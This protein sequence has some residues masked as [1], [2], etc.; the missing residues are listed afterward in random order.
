MRKTK[1]LFKG[2]VPRGNSGQSSQSSMNSGEI[3][4]LKSWN[5]S[6]R[7]TN[8]FHVTNPF[9]S[10][11]EEIAAEGMIASML[12]C[13]VMSDNES[14]ADQNSQM[15]YFSQLNSSRASSDSANFVSGTAMNCGNV[16]PP[17]NNSAID[18]GDWPNSNGEQDTS[19]D[20]SKWVENM[21]AGLAFG[22]ITPQAS[23]DVDPLGSGV[24][25]FAASRNAVADTA[26]TSSGNQLGKRET[27]KE[28][29]LQ[30]YTFT[31]PPVL[32]PSTFQLEGT[33]ISQYAGSDGRASPSSGITGGIK[34]TEATREDSGWSMA[35]L[36][37]VQA[38]LVQENGDHAQRAEVL[39]KE[40]DELRRGV[41]EMKMEGRINQDKMETSMASVKGL[42]EKRISEMTAIMAQRDQQADERLKLISETMHRRDI[43]VD[44]RMVNLITTVQDLTLG[45]KAVAATVPSRP[46]PVPV[47]LNAANVP[48]TSAF[49]TQPPTN[50]EVVQRQSGTK[51]DKRNLNPETVEEAAKGNTL[52]TIHEQALAEAII[53]AMSKGLE[54]L[55]A[56][57]EA[58]NKP[59][60]YRG[61]RDGIIDGWLV[62][63]KRYLEKAHS[64]DTTLE[65]AWTIVEFLE[66][67][68]QDYITN[69]SEAERD[70]DEKIFAL[71]ARRFGTGST[72][73]QIQQLFRTRNQS[74]DEDYMQYLDA[75]ENLRSQGIPNEEITVRR[76]EIMQ[77][78]VEGVRSFELK[79]NLA[80]MYAQEQYVDTPPTVEALRFTVQQYLHMRGSIR[81]ENYPAPQQKPL[82]ASQQNPIPAAAP[83]VPNVQPPPQPVAVRQ[84]PPRACFNCGDPS[85]FVADCPLKDRARKP[86]QQ[87]VNSCRTN[88]AGE[89]TFPSNPHGMNN[90]VVPAALAAQGP[91]TIRVNCDCTGHTASECMVPENAATEEQVKA[92]WYAPVTKSA[93]FA[94]TDD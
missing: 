79:R 60:K 76:Y 63:M 8:S 85:H 58:K 31:T 3:E 64:K 21:N 46:L 43:D 67:E 65:R 35:Q 48:S 37:Q 87:L 23:L 4:H 75:L 5:E 7:Q 11:V 89:W 2:W 94:D 86:V 26:S 13:D 41:I 9:A 45:V 22:K 55:L 57:K 27:V 39:M 66:N 18:W 44:K 42:T 29:N 30:S 84:Q 16:W 51:P 88:P 78:F 69:K 1:V 6:S 40:I 38:K 77:R 93:D 47:A 74:N 17:M 82:L 33:A 24:P 14:I 49:S 32:G 83:Q 71:L 50:R 70:T 53:T 34:E 19:S 68:A 61:T 12:L 10:D 91:P 72:K 56:A 59:T 62:L 54:P 92:A 20:I 52:N 25:V 36:K 81:S 73:I 90:D 80:L 28:V 15:A